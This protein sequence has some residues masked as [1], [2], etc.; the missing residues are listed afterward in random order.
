MREIRTCGS[1]GGA[2]LTPRSYPYQGVAL[3]AAIASL[4]FSYLRIRQVLC[5]AL[6]WCGGAA[7]DEAGDEGFDEE[8]CESGHD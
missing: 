7:G 3:A 1:E 2:R 8:E 5:P 4:E 6:R